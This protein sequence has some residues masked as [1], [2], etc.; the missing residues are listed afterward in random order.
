[1]HVAVWATDPITLT[2]ITA[3][4]V[5][6]LDVIIAADEFEDEVDVLVLATDRVNAEV[7]ASVG[8]AAARTNAPA[9][10]VTNEV[11]K[12]GPMARSSSRGHLSPRL[13]DRAHLLDGSAVDVRPLISNLIVNPHATRVKALQLCPEGPRR[14][15]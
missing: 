4:L 14:H 13:L 15:R 7:L 9:V 11:D 8:K 6:G 1:M 12:S 2:G 5:D 10:L 3:I